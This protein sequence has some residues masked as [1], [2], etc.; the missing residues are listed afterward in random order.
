MRDQLQLQPEDFLVRRKRPRHYRLLFQAVLAA[1]VF[2]PKATAFTPSSIVG[3]SDRRILTCLTNSRTTSSTSKKTRK[4]P[5]N[6]DAADEVPKQN[7]FRWMFEGARSRGTQKVS[8]DQRARVLVIFLY[9]D[10]WLTQGTNLLPHVAGY[11]ERSCGT[12]WRPS[13]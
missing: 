11:A 8:L 9:N 2:L 3:P 10:H 5:Y 1:A 13:Q 7:W 12:R 6:A 4:K